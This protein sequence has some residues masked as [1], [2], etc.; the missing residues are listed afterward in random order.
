MKKIFLALTAVIIML[1]GTSCSETVKIPS[2]NTAVEENAVVTVGDTEYV[3]HISY[4]NDMTSCVAFSSPANL[5]GMTFRKAEDSVSVS[6]GTL[7]CK[8]GN[9]GFSDNCVFVQI[10]DELAKMKQD[11]IKF[12]SK[13][14]D[15]Y[16]FSLK[17]DPVCK[18]MTDSDGH[19][20]SFTGKNIKIKF[21]V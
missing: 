9:F 19:I 4:V 21:D 11:N 13:Q 20:I 5:K 10:T 8:S 14:G 17:S 18:F 6:L 7:I 12:L 3:C 1:V 2:V 16:M 15:N